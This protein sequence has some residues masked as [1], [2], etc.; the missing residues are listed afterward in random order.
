MGCHIEDLA[1][2]CKYCFDRMTVVA[3]QFKILNKGNKLNILYMVHTIQY[4][5]CC[6]RS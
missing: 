6:L 4:S 5:I 1:H 2:R 3:W